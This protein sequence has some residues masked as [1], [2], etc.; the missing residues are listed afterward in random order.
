MSR[1]IRF[2]TVYKRYNSTLRPDTSGWSVYDCVFKE[3]FDLDHPTVIIKNLAS[4]PLAWNMFYLAD[5]ASY[6]WITSAVAVSNGRWEISGEIDVLGT[7]KD[8][9]TNTQCY[10]EYGNN[11]DASGAVYR[12]RDARQNVANVPTVATSSVDITGGVMDLTEGTFILSCVG[13]KSGVVTY[14]LNYTQMSRIMDS[15]TANIWAE[16]GEITDFVE[17]LNF[18]ATHL[19]SQGSAI[20]AIRACLWLPIKISSI[21]HGTAQE[22]YLGDFPT[23][24]NGFTV[25]SGSV[26]I[27]DTVL[28]IPWPVDDWRRMNCQIL[29]YVP[30]IG[31]VS[32]PVD[33]CNG[34]SQ[35]NI[36]WCLEPLGGGISVRI[37]AGSYTVY[38]GSGNIGIP[39]AIGS[40]NVT[41]MQAV[42]GLTQAVGGAL[43][44]G[45]GILSGVGAA[46]GVV[47]GAEQV[48]SAAQT[49]APTIQ[50]TGTLGGNAAYGQSTNAELCL[51]YYPPID[52]SGFSAVYGHPVMRVATPVAGYCKTRGFSC[53][54]S[55]RS[56][57]LG[58]IS[59]LMDTGV[60][61]E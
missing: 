41:G 40:S 21:P 3:G 44:A 24:V 56:S 7:Y 61:I 25:P 10:I 32:I 17:S 36:R 18:L 27:K 30:F 46:T 35:L 8:V 22:I 12:L 11:T 23:N 39:Y 52:D 29:V 13:Q 33:Q 49:I 50:C 43:T 58:L 47:S 26:L 19:L 1:E 53:G 59:T 42:T 38:T 9:I 5:T 48:L 14:R 15:V 34:V 31:T 4:E 51:N 57:E 54:A 37:N 28:P 16:S 20:D 2:G 55:A 45:T 60:F 6:Y